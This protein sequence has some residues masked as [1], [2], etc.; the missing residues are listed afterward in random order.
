MIYTQA[1]CIEQDNRKCAEDRKDFLQ[2]KQI[3]LSNKKKKAMDYNLHEYTM[4]PAQCDNQGQK[5][6]LSL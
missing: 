5:G 2:W 3:D 6:R 1:I 4:Q